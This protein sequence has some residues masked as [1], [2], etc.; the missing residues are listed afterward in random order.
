MT[1]RFQQPYFSNPPHTPIIPAT[2]GQEMSVEPAI[3]PTQPD[4]FEPRGGEAYGKR[5]KNKQKNPEKPK[6]SIIPMVVLSVVALTATGF[7]VWAVTHKE[8]AGKLL[9]NAKEGVNKLFK[10]TENPETVEPPSANGSTSSASGTPSSTAIPSSSTASIAKTPVKP[11]AKTTATS[12]PV[13]ASA[14]AKTTATSPPVTASAATK[15]IAT[16]PPVTASA[17]SP[18]V[19][20]SAAATSTPT[21]TSTTSTAPIAKPA[22]IANRQK[23]VIDRGNLGLL[24]NILGSKKNHILSFLDKR[25]LEG[26]LNKPPNEMKIN[27][28][29]QIYNLQE[30][31]IALPNNQSKLFARHLLEALTHPTTV[32]F[33]DDSLYNTP[34]QKRLHAVHLLENLINAMPAA[35]RG[36]L[37]DEVNILV[38]TQIDTQL[39]QKLTAFLNATPDNVNVKDVEDILHFH[40]RIETLQPDLIPTLRQR[41]LND[42]ADSNSS[43]SSYY[44]VSPLVRD[45]IKPTNTFNE[46]A[47]D[48]INYNKLTEITTKS[49]FAPTYVEAVKNLPDNQKTILKGLEDYVKNPY[50]KKNHPKFTAFFAYLK[51]NP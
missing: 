8:E 9:D 36:T 7:G 3:Q 32:A 23:V 10:K 17:T 15:T 26:I 6:K 47:I 34:L 20:A 13:T 41:I 44:L 51:D 4:Q 50:N 1:D 5:L 2:L 24:P 28:F 31:I 25:T 12:P 40:Y 37:E 30:E 45:S 35:E 33:A 16:S 39:Q 43:V 27:Q 48:I 38:D 14:A 21:T 42:L 29:Y 19:T 49:G 18:P 46:A 11:A 22:T